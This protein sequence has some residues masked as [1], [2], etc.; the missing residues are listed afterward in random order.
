MP[1]DPFQI[2]LP[3]APLSRA[4]VAAA[5][6]F[7]DWALQLRTYRR[8]YGLLDSDGRSFTEAALEVLDIQAECDEAGITRVPTHGPLIVAANHPQGAVDGLALAAVLGRVRPDVRLLANHLVARVPEMRELSFFVDPFDG[9]NATARSVGGLRAAHLWLRRGGAVIIFPAG[10]VAHRRRADGSV[11]DSLWKPTIGRL[12]LATGAQIVPAFIEGGNSRLFY[13]AGRIHPALRTVLLPRELLRARGRR[14]RVRMGEALS[15]GALPAPAVEAEAVTRRV[16][17]AVDRIGLARPRP[18]PAAEAP[19]EAPAGANDLETDVRRLSA[20]ALLVES[21][22]LQVFCAGA[23]QLPHILRE[24][25]RLREIT[26]RSIGEGT[27]RELD[28]DRFDNRYLHLFV[29]QRARREV[30]GAYRI[31]R[32]DRI[33]AGAGVEAL[34][35]RS[36]FE[37]DRRLI[38]RL[39]PA[40]ELGRSFVRIEYQKTHSALLLLWKGI[41]RFVARHPQYRT[42]FG[43]V[44]ISSRYADTSRQ[45]LMT[46]LEQNHLDRPLAELVAATNPPP[47]TRTAAAG[48]AVPC[49]PDDVNDIV[50]QFESDGKGMPVLLRQYLKLNARLL[51]FNVDPHFG[52]ALDALMMVDLTA[53]DPAILRRYFGAQDAAAFLDHHR[54]GSASRAA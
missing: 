1:G 21:G 20:S 6:P 49:A 18:S 15:P 33:V 29:W 35:T 14:V 2:D 54:P 4:A 24:I 31:A 42:L 11:A 50:A 27:G 3:V 25:G 23:R 51:G 17:D 44:S 45:L 30:V 10:E 41:C 16:R 37:Y 52:D 5:R 32:T 9:R 43:A 48:V 39:S 26:Y 13:L 53:V 7:L 46:F 47:P 40:L 19:P 28:L 22:D 34:Y 12:A 36:L 8:L 38:E